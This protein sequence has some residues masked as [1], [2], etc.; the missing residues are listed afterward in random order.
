MIVSGSAIIKSDKPKEVIDALRATTEKWIKINS[1]GSQW[2]IQFISNI[3]GEFFG[4]EFCQ[5]WPR[6]VYLIGIFC[7]VFIKLQE[8]SIQK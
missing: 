7:K 4:I 2:V 8:H 5:W 3:Y 1:E 6:I